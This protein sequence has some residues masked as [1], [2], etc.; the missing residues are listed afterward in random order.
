[1]FESSAPKRTIPWAKF[2]QSGKKV[3]IPQQLTAE[4]K[5]ALQK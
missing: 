1:M 2:D 4:E 3:Q 5:L